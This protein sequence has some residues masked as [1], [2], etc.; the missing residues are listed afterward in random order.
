MAAPHHQEVSGFGPLLR[1]HRTTAGLSQEALAERAGLSTR[2]VSDLERGVKTRP[3]PATMR[4]LADALDLD[5]GQRAE[6]AA[7]SRPS[8]TVPSPSSPQELAALPVPH[9]SIV[10]RTQELVTACDL[11]RS[12]NVRLLTLTG[13]GGVGKTRLALELAQTTASDYSSGA[14]FVELA[15]IANP[16]LVPAAIAGAL[17]IREDRDRSLI[18]SIRERLCTD[19][20]LLVL[21][22]CE[23]LLAGV[24]PLVANLLGTAPE[25]TVLATNRG[26]LR[27][28]HEQLLPVP[29]LALPGRGHAPQVESLAA[30]PAIDLFVQRALA[31]APD[32]ALTRANAGDVAEICARLDGLPLAIELAAVRIRSLSPASLV[33]LLGAR[34][35]LLTTG[36]HDAP[37]RQRTL[38]AAIEWSH[39]LLSSEHQALMR[40]LAVFAGG[41]TLESAAAVSKGDDLFATLDGIEA[42]V[43]GGLLTRV[44]GIDGQPRYGMLETVREFA[45]EEL[46][47]S[48]DATI[49]H[50]AHAR[51]QIALVTEAGA[52]LHGPTPGIWLDR[53]AAEQDNVRAALAWSLG[54]SGSPGDP[55][56]ALRLAAALWP[57]WHRRGHLQE[58]HAWL[59]RAVAQG[60]RVDPATRAPAFL[61]LANIA[62]NLEDLDQAGT[63]YRTSLDLF[64][65]LGNKTGAA[66][67]LTGLGMV[68]TSRGDYERAETSLLQGLA[69]WREAENGA[70]TMACLYAFGR[71]AAAQGLYDEAADRFAEARALCDPRDAGSLAYLR[72]EIA[73][74]ERQRG[75]LAI[76]LALAE[77]CLAQFRE[78]GERR[79]E[80][81]T[82]AELAHLASLNSDA[83]QSTGYFLDAIL[84]HL[85]LRD[86]FGVVTCLEGMAMLASEEHRPELVAR[87][88][89][90]AD[91][92]RRRTGTVRTVAEREAFQHMTSLNREVL[93]ETDFER[94]WDDWSAKGL[95]QTA[96]LAVQSFRRTDR[97]S[98]D[99]VDH[100]GE[101]AGSSGTR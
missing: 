39:D 27:L 35:R 8:A 13:P 31:V 86:E 17:G 45:L 43:D 37:A 101:R 72:L 62:N 65:Q 80:A 79:A 18:E 36:P 96:A 81:T 89:S 87:L 59:E 49:V 50:A 61:T 5:L 10:G 58:G 12:G 48:D 71:L 94:A 77:E 28:R 56:L 29:P 1:Q 91:A 4:L 57:W 88:A 74:V 83:G 11:L 84:L 46:A 54:E 97:S 34:L 7:A 22:N 53:I 42:L 75:N 64:E 2:A 47:A 6:L 66:A 73:Q 14:V 16:D 51:R 15:P 30:I 24:Q 32:F 25:L 55:E 99:T 19:R 95:D 93:G 100:R 67:A 60:D 9:A 92:W 85:E 76:A 82:L 20:L 23:H 63:L 69:I 78:I 38:R 21:D 70:G 52:H 98:N 44:D 3:H 68:A 26:P 40:R 41:F 90:T 33:A